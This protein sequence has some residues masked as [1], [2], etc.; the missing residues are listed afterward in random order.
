MQRYSQNIS[1]SF[2]LGFA[3]V[4]AP[5]VRD[6][7]Q[8]LD[9][10]VGALNGAIIGAFQGQERQSQQTNLRPQRSRPARPTVSQSQRQQTREVQTALNFFEFSADGIDGVMGPN[11]RKAIRA[12]EWRRRE[13]DGAME[14]FATIHRWIVQLEQPGGP[15]DHPMLLVQSVASAPG[16]ESCIVGYVDANAISNAKALKTHVAD[17][18]VPSFECCIDEMKNHGATT[19]TDN[20][21]A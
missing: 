21:A 2:G 12:F 13:V 8:D 9:R 16:E 17:E 3:V 10:A 5:V 14:P 1:L 11:T 20:A 7:A 4:L 6:A 18:V 19:G 15:R